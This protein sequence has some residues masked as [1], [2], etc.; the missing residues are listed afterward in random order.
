MPF[1]MICEH[2]QK[3][4]YLPD[5]VAGKH[6]KCS[7]CSQVIQAPMLA[8]ANH[9]VV[10]VQEVR[11]A[12]IPN[13]GRRQ[14]RQPSVSQSSRRPRQPGR[15][16]RQSRPDPDV[17]SGAG[18]GSYGHSVGMPRALERELDAEVTRENVPELFEDFDALIREIVIFFIGF[19]I[20]S[21]ALGCLAYAVLGKDLGDEGGGL[22][23]YLIVLLSFSGILISMALLSLTR[24]PGVLGALSALAFSLAVISSIYVATTGAW[25]LTPVPFS[26]FVAMQRLQRAWTLHP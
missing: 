8:A 3:Q 25:L 10:D 9:D 5:E 15:R 22:P 16:K 24:V 19:G 7:G 20:I 21:A 2:C 12:V 18:V 14:K 4:F 6:F 1:S 13:A 17:F 26:L 11:D 23:G